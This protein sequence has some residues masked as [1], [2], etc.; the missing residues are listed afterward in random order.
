MRLPVIV[1][2]LVAMLSSQGFRLSA[3]NTVMGNQL[4]LIG[5]VTDEAPKECSIRLMSPRGELADTLVRHESGSIYPGGRV[6]RSRDRIAYCLQLEKGDSQFRIVNSSGNSTV[7]A[8]GQGMVTAWSHDDR[9]FAAYRPDEDSKAFESLIIDV[10]TG[11]E[12]LLKLP[13]HYVG[14]DWHPQTGIRTALYLNPRNRMYRKI[15]GDSYPARQLDLFAEDG[16]LKPLTRNPSTDNIWSKY[17]PD[18][19]RIAHY[20]RTLDGETVLEYAVVCEADGTEPR[21]VF[22]FTKFGIANGLPWFR[23]NG[24]PAWS[25]DGSMLAW[26]VDSNADATSVGGKLELLLVPVNSGEPQRILLAAEKGISRV[27]GI[28]WR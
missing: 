11:E 26:L 21:V 19:V 3:D 1:Y 24:P 23:P 14:D 27:S 15:K 18:G 5:A 25:P 8:S 28:D 6:S 10:K 16:T 9:W 13:P 17:S 22:E 4:V 12:T 7:V 2:F 20:G